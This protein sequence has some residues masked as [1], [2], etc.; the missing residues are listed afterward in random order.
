MG[1]K[2]SSLIVVKE[3]LSLGNVKCQ[4][5]MRWRS[6]RLAVR[7]VGRSPSIEQLPPAEIVAGSLILIHHQLSC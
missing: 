5:P 6:E 7:R 1:G 4:W 3:S 2:D